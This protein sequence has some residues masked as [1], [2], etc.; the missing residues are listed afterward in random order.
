MTRPGML[1]EKEGVRVEGGGW[2]ERASERR[3]DVILLI[4]GLPCDDAIEQPR[5]AVP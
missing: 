2:R 5:A 1:R 4:E 3:G